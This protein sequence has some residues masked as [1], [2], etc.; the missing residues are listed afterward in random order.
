MQDRGPVNKDRLPQ[1]GVHRIASDTD[2]V[3]NTAFIPQVTS[4]N[5]CRPQESPDMFDF[6]P[7]TRVS[8]SAATRDPEKGTKERKL[9]A[10]R[11]AEASKSLQ[12]LDA[13]A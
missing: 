7:R 9:L 13:R 3:Q 12:D 2:K 1:L 6:T 4:T 10:R 11:L 5:K 8:L